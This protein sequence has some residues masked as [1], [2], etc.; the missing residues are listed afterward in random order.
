MTIAILQARQDK[1]W[2]TIEP[3]ISA[4]TLYRL[5]DTSRNLNL[6]NERVQLLRPFSMKTSKRIQIAIRFAKLNDDYKDT[7]VD[8]F[9]FLSMALT[10]RAIIEVNGHRTSIEDIGQ[11]KSDFDRTT[12]FPRNYS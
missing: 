11:R 9:R 1:S 12:F 2:I 8:S 10:E 7:S 4:N 5:R 3:L 6:E